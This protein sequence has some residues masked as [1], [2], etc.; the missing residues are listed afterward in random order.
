MSRKQLYSR[1][2]AYII[3]ALV[4]VIILV[5]FQIFPI[6]KLITDGLDSDSI[7]FF[8]LIF[9]A[10]TVLLLVYRKYL[11]DILLKDTEVFYGKVLSFKRLPGTRAQDSLETCRFELTVENENSSRKFIIFPEPLK[12]LYH[13]DILIQTMMNCVVHFEY[14]KRTKCV[15]SII[16]IEAENTPLSKKQLTKKERQLHQKKEILKRTIKKQQ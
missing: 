2:S 13:T 12:Q 5:I 11:L 8:K 15:V 3:N 7:L 16:Y 14:L 10:E 4:P 6:I 1:T 9:I